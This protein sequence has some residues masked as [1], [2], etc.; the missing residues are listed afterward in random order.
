MSNSK[1]ATIPQ[2][3]VIVP[4]YNAQQYLTLT[5]ESLLTQRGVDIRVIVVDDHSTDETRRLVLNYAKGDA[6]VCYASTMENSGGPAGPRN[7]GVER[8][9]TE[10]IAFCDADDLW[11]G[12]KLSAQLECARTKGADLV[13]TEIE[14]FLDGFEPRL[15]GVP[16]MP[17]L[18]NRRIGLWQMLLK[19]RV[20][21]SSVLCRRSQVLAAGGFNVERSMIAVEDYDLWLRLMT[22]LDVR[23]VRLGQPLVAYRHLAGSLSASKWRQACKIMRVHKN[24]FAIKG[25]QLLFPFVAPVLMVCYI[26]SWLYLRSQVGRLA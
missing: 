23:I 16:L 15:F 13:C 3:T 25:W 18:S 1:A 9:N 24:I 8:A 5:L 22:C 14:P 6:R 19:N 26:S 10:W 12:D 21:T 4:A 2:V 11:H 20:A 7:I 17:Q